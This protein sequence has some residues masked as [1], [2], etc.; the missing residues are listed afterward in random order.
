LVAIG[1]KAGK[2]QRLIARELD[3]TEATIRRDLEAQGITRTKQPTATIRKPAVV[4]KASSPA[5]SDTKVVSLNPAKSLQPAPTPTKRF[6]LPPRPVFPRRVVPEPLKPGPPKHPS[7]EIPLSPEQHLEEMLQLVGSW[8]REQ[9]PKYSR[10][11]TVLDKARIR[12][13]R[14]R[15]FPV[16]ELTESPRSAAQL[17][18]STRPLELDTAR[19]TYRTEEV[20]AQWLVNWLAAWE[21]K[22]KKL[23][24]KVIDQTRARV[25]AD[26]QL[27]NPLPVHSP[28]SPR[29]GVRRR[30]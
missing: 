16:P 18:D 1:I 13:A 7:P 2:S 17:R 9:R 21:P 8:L 25:T 11:E 5:T 14:R 27:R 12:L 4:F 28:F 15:N 20:C 19:G 3:V 29:R 10:E 6:K 23:R 26:V 30:P 24:D 22:D